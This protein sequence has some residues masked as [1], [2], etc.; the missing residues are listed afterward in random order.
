MGIREWANKH[1]KATI[2]IVSAIIVLTI[3]AIVFQILSNRQTYP[4]D[5][6]DGYFTID[7]GKTFFAAKVSNIPPFDAEGGKAVRAYVFAG[8]NGKKFVGYLERFNAESMKLVAAGKTLTPY[9]ARFGRELKRPG[10]T[11]W[12]KT[13]DPKIEAA[14]TDVKPPDG[15]DP[16]QLV[17]IDP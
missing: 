2:G 1:Q 5:V 13:G 9:Q 7:D 4:T 6:P 8:G 11:Q 16:S 17:A 14:V 10:A 3:G 15:G 12:I